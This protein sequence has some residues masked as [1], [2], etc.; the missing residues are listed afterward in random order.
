V[1]LGLLVVALAAEVVALG[2]EVAVWV[3]VRVLVASALDVE[4]RLAEPHPAAARATP[5]IA[6]NGAQRR[7]L[8]S[9][10]TP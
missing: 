2:V 8:A 6:T 5:S 9:M 4:C 3:T 1:A 7:R 10:V